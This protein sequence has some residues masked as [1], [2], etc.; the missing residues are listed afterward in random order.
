[1]SFSGKSVSRIVSCVK[2]PPGFRAS[3]SE[4]SSPSLW[5]IHLHPSFIYHRSKPRATFGS[6][7]RFLFFPC[8]LAY[9]SISQLHSLEMKPIYWIKLSVFLVCL[10]FFSS[11]FS[12]A[13]ICLTKG[14]SK[15]FHLRSPPQKGSVTSTFFQSPL[16]ILRIDT[17]WQ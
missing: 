7:T 12:T 15:V 17:H 6:K 16:H 14:V 13:P 2:N 8:L 11:L 1:M 4:S 10:S 5:I 9:L 3:N